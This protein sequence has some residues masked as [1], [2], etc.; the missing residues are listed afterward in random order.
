MPSTILDLDETFPTNGS[1]GSI[2][3]L[4]PSSISSSSTYITSLNPGYN[5]S[6]PIRGMNGVSTEAAT[7]S[8][9]KP[10]NSPLGLIP[11]YLIASDACHLSLSTSK[12]DVTHSLCPPRPA[13][14][15][16]RRTPSPSSHTR[17]GTVPGPHTRSPYS[18]QTSKGVVP[19]NDLSADAKEVI[20]GLKIQLAEV[21]KERDEAQRFVRDVKRLLGSFTAGT[22]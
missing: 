17:L 3:L 16:E 5:P 10:S 13:K 18:P 22:G 19:E 14:S 1:E 8:Q 7:P 20:N 4:Q 6:N 11:S 9:A 2:E 12:G 21:R 15:P